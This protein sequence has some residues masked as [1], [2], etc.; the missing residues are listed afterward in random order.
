MPPE[1]LQMLVRN[2]GG[3]GAAFAPV[4]VG[5]VPRY[6]R[7]ESRVA[8]DRLEERL[9]RADR[10]LEERDDLTLSVYKGH[11][12]FAG[13]AGKAPPR[14]PAVGHEIPEIQRVVTPTCLNSKLHQGLPH[15]PAYS[16]FAWSYPVSGQSR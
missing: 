11:D 12:M 14:G 6:P 15:D 4:G 7:F 3:A 2:D 8:K 5:Q 13:L 9:I 16:G 1:E 10:V